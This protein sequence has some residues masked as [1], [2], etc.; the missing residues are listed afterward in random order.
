MKYV[1]LALALILG[2]AAQA[3]VPNGLTATQLWTQ[4]NDRDSNVDTFNLLVD[5]QGLAAGVYTRNADGTDETFYMKDIAKPDGVVLIEAQGHK[6]MFL[7]GQVDRVT[8]QG[9]FH[10]KW[11]SNGLTNQYTTCDFKL[12]HTGATYF[13]QNVHT[14]AKITQMKIISWSLGLKDLQGICE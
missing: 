11:L 8:Q 2:T 9:T 13:A 4:T 3:G 1:T 6:V 14:N 7:Q 5:A 10:I 12:M